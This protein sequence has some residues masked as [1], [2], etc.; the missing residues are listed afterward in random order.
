MLL[1]PGLATPSS[2][3]T[4]I[5]PLLH[6]EMCRDWPGA[7]WIQTPCEGWLRLLTWGHSDS[8]RKTFKCMQWLTGVVTAAL[9]AEV[10][11]I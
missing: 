4:S 5:P 8:V 7:S 2:G 9:E 6:L 3:I 10:G 1:F 11:G